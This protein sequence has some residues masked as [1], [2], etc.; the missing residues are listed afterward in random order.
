MQFKKK[1]KPLIK[2]LNKSLINK[3]YLSWLNDKDNQKKIDLKKKSPLGNLKNIFVKTK[4]GE[5]NY[6]PFFTKKNILET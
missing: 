2:I 4:K 1:E 5:I 6:M 3:R